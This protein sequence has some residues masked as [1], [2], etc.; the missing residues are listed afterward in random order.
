VAA[1]DN[2][3]DIRHLALLS[4]VPTP[5]ILLGMKCYYV[6]IHGRLE[7]RPTS[8]TN[9]IGDETSQPLGFY[10]H[11]YV[12]ASSISSAEDSAFRRVRDNLDRQTGWLTTNHV[13]LEL[14]AEEITPA[15]IFRL[16]KSD[17]RGHIFYDKE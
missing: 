1:Y 3:G 9:D 17:N 2:I 12:L 6:L 10:C 8:T 13:K 5:S 11:R 14:N 15:P 4:F 16:L 7:W